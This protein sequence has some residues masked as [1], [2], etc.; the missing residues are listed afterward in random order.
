MSDSDGFDLLIIGG[1]PAGLTAAIYGGRM[2]LKTAVYENKGFGGLAGT[3]PKIENYPGFSSING[4]ELTEKMREQAESWGATLFYDEVTA[5]NPKEMTISTYGGKTKAKAIIIA[6]GS[7]HLSLGLSNEYELVGNG[8]S[9]CATCDG[10]LFRDK[11]VAAVG[12]GNA[13]GLEVIYLSNIAKKVYL[14]HR[15]HCMRA[16]ACIAD[17]VDSLENVVPLYNCVIEEAITKNDK[18]GALKVK[19]IE[20]GEISNIDVNALFIA[21]G[22]E[23]QSDLAKN[24]GIELDDDNCIKVNKNQETNFSGIYAAGDVTGGIRQVTTAVGEGTTAAMNAYL[25]IKQGWYGDGVKK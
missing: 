18:L 3:A 20:T 16:E 7:K 21:I 4:L 25:Y 19:N 9:Y 23:P 15:R 24:V 11:E 6:T 13:A 5:I 8:I 2:G 1:G 10:P 14:I 12:G 22:V 17:E